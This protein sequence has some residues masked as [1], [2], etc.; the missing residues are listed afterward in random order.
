MRRRRAVLIMPANLPRILPA[1]V[2]SDSINLDKLPID[3]I[4]HVLLQYLDLSTIISLSQVSHFFREVL[5]HTNPTFWH[6]LLAI[7]L[8]YVYAGSSPPAHVLAYNLIKK[9][10]SCDECLGKEQDVSLRRLFR[11]RLCPQCKAL[12]K[13]SM[14]TMTRAKREFYLD[15]DDL[16]RIPALR[17]HNPHGYSKPKMH[18]YP[19]VDVRKRCEEKLRH[20]GTT[21]A[22]RK[23]QGK[24]R[25]AQIK[26][27]KQNAV[28]RRRVQLTEALEEL[29]IP[30]PTDSPELEDCCAKFIDNYNDPLDPDRRMSFEDVLERIERDHLLM[31]H[32]PYELIQLHLSQLPMHVLGDHRFFA[33]E[34]EIYSLR[35][36]QMTCEEVEKK[37]KDKGVTVQNCACGKPLLENALFNHWR[38]INNV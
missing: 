21:F 2:K 33:A 14:I 17:T 24:E 15:D 37:E 12:D 29:G 7:R 22:E 13:Y 30:Y 38:E 18:L 8:K 5:V 11:K 4:D 26:L 34:T 31:E 16:S 25:G 32:S 6:D 20:Q 28:Q 27:R 36:L 1:S 10:R 3:I 23:Q 9:R 35:F 19:L